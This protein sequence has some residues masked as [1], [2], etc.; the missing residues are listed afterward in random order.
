MKTIEDFKKRMKAPGARVSTKKYWKNL[1]GEWV[2]QQEYP[3]REV[4]IVQT[5]SFAL[6]T[7]IANN[8]QA[9]DSW[10]DWPKKNE[11]K[12]L[13]LHTVEITSEGGQFKIVYQFL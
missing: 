7:V 2:L 5:N 13:D 3:S 1:K 8:D 11:F 6:K 9:K 10:C 12:I 4:S